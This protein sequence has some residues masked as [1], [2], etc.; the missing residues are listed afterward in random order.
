M[1]ADEAI[2]ILEDQDFGSKKT[3]CQTA[4]VTEKGLPLFRK[5]FP[6]FPV[7]HIIVID[8][9]ENVIAPLHIL[10]KPKAKKQAAKRPPV[11]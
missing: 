9:E 7:D 5:K 2:A 8:E 1:K 3:A 10:G 6:N 4:T 11:S